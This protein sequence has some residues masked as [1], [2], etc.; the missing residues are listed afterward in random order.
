MGAGVP[1]ARVTATNQDTGV[2]ISIETT[3]AGTYDFP[4]VLPG[5]YTVTVEAAGFTRV[6][7]VGVPVLADQDNVADAKLELGTATAT[8]EVVAGAVQVQTTDSSLNNDF[9]AND[10][11]NLPI[12][13]GTLNGSPLNLAVLAP[14]VVA[15]PGG[16]TGIGALVGGT[17][18]RD[19][20]FVVHSVGD[21]NLGL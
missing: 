10:V 9:D 4:S 12:A 16:V 14:N 17:R 5:K 15:Q 3:S 18:P 8:V 6:V 11:G 7:K 19:T 20:K 2:S 1:N 13:A 21:T